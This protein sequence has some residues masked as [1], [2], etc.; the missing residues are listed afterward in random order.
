MVCWL[1]CSSG[2]CWDYSVEFLE[3]QTAI[4]LF[5]M[6]YSNS[7]ITNQFCLE[8][9]CCRVSLSFDYLIYPYYPAY[10]G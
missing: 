7:T 5:R 9:I 3:R 8:I 10:M 2:F 1:P 4:F 6:N